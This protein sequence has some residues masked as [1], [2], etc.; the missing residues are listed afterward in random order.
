MVV[1]ELI[2]VLS[3]P[4][5]V[6]HE[7]R[8]AVCMDHDIVPGGYDLS[9]LLLRRVPGRGDVVIGPLEYGHRIDVRRR[10]SQDGV[11]AR[12]MPPENAERPCCRV[13]EERNVVDAETVA[14]HDDESSQW[15]L[16]DEGMKNFGP[17]LLELLR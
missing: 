16:A 10:S 3:Q 2:Q 13:D 17:R 11:C 8:P 4:P 15:S 7:P 1:S 6:V 14:R 9:G 5:L 12:H